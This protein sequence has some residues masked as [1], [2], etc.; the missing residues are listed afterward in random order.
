MELQL[1]TG[2]FVWDMTEDMSREVQIHTKPATYQGPMMV[3]LRC[4]RNGEIATIVDYPELPPA[5]KAAYEFI[6][7]G[8]S[9]D[10]DADHDTIAKRLLEE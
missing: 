10:A 3:T 9:P 4:Y 5:L 7:E 8:A 1:K 2:T 6:T